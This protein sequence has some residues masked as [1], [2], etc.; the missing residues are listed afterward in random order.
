VYRLDGVGPGG[1]DVI[2]KC[3]SPERIRTEQLIY[4][5]VL[6]GLPLPAVRYYG[7]VDESDAGRCWLF[8]EYADGEAYS[9]RDEEHRAVAGRWLGLLHAS[10]SRAVRADGLPDRG[11]G[12]YFGRLR[13]AQDRILSGLADP[14]IAAGDRALLEAV[15]GQCEV[16]ASHWGQVE[17][18]CAG[19]TRSLIHGDFAPKNMR[20]RTGP[21]GATLLPFDW[22]SAGWGVPAA[23]L[24]QSG[25]AS[26]LW[27]YWASPDLASYCSALRGSWPHHEVR[28]L[29]PVSAVG[30][31]FR[32][33]V[34]I[35]LDA[36]DP[37]VGWAQGSARNMRDYQA[38]M[39]DAIRMMG[40]S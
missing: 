7:V 27:S 25:A 4:E 33:L 22:G 1:S 30:K 35:D 16:V 8:L 14:A 5:E 18:L 32:C 21:A 24:A 29:Q 38:E 39:D 3:S 34:C 17:G 6:P 11:P 40:W 28:D 13:S 36:P 19:L 10:A 2:A 9:P 37:A 20:V 23:D 31:I 26:G 15:A 12:Y